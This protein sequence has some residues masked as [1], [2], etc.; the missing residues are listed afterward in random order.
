MDC[1]R[2][3]TPTTAHV[4]AK[5]R[6]LK[7]LVGLL[8]ALLLLQSTTPLAAQQEEVW[9]ALL[10]EQLD[11]EKSCRLNYTTNVRK[12]DIDGQQGL[13]ARAHCFDKRMYDVTW[14]P[15]KQQFEIQSCEP[16]VC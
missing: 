7:L 2:L 3:I 6:W 16:A 4:A 14:L 10:R 1:C 15:E 13:K 11:D 5:S 9:Q 8:A 12:Y